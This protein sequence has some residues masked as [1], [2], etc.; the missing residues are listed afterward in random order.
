MK[1][2][3]GNK[4]AMA[5]TPSEVLNWRLYWSTFVFGRLPQH[6]VWHKKKTN[7]SVKVF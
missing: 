7:T 3:L 5:E 4:A 6:T 2:T 1:F